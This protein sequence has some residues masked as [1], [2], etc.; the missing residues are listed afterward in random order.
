MS[1]PVPEVRVNDDLPITSPT[2]AAALV[3]STATLL[4]SGF[5]GVGYPKLVP[6]AVA[7][8]DD[9]RELTVISGG[10]VG[11]E[12][13]RD[14]VESGDMVRRYPF[15]PNETSR[16]AVNDGQIQFHD[17]HISRLADEVR[18]GGLHT[19]IR[20]E[21]IAVVE[22]VAV[23][24]GW[25]IPSTSIGHTPAYVGVADRLIIE[26]NRAQPVDLARVH[27]IHVREDPPHRDPIPLDDPLGETDG[28]AVQFDTA[29]LAAV[30][31]TDR[32]DDPY[33]F[34]EIS[35]TD[36]AIADNLGTFLEAELDRNPLFDE[37]ANLQ[38]GV[39]SLGNAL[40]G[41]LADIDF[42]DR[43]VS[44]VGEVVQDG[45]LDMVDAGDLRGV[46]ATSLALSAEGQ[47]RFF[48]DIERYAEDVVLRPADIS[49]APELIDRFGVVGVNS[50]VEVDLHGN[51]NAT[52][53][54][55]SRV[56]SGIGGGGDFARN[57]RLGII[58][59]PS[60]AVGGD[61]SR[62]VPLTPHVDHTEHDASVIVTEHGIADLRGRSPR[63]RADAL[64]E[65]ADPAFRESLS[66][67]S[68]RAADEGGNT[69]QNLDMAFSLE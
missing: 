26:V 15:V 50:A 49:N 55:G 46:S 5:G 8:A 19:G 11:D 58:A 51:V 22:A 67:Y 52:H 31:E 48:D 1:D 13:D 24:Q 54:G 6:E 39:G 38:F 7:A 63:E 40:M 68:D 21:S 17:R 66:E 2:S 65:I 23:G 14:L 57:C 35:Q 12:I 43:S 27:D 30:V 60:T 45:L 4:V 20:G 42:G 9:D 29:K 34:R 53:I 28:P 64:V 59:L 16:A 3:P 47:E 62:I 56:V 10:G 69:P 33:E 18:F 25:L 36:Q 32:S 41:A 61:V 37:A 44:Y